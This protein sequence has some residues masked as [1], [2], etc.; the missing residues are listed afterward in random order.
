MSEQRIM[1]RN[2]KRWLRCK[3]TQGSHLAAQ[4]PPQGCR[5]SGP[6]LLCMQA[7]ILHHAGELV[8][9]GAGDGV[10][11]HGGDAIWFKDAAWG[12]CMGWSRAGA[13]LRAE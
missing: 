1:S 2:N 9:D 5:C 11:L 6:F 10:H 7:V 13:G 3:Q 12:G 8:S 4:R